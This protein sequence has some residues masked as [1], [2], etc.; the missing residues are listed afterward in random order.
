MTGILHLVKYE[1]AGNDF[2]VCLDPSGRRPFSPAEV[3]AL[4]DRHHGVG[5]DGLVRVLA[6][7]DGV[8]VRMELHNADGSAA[9]MSGNGV[10][11]VA[12]AVL[13][14][15]GPTGGLF[16]TAGAA[17]PSGD[18]L[19]AAGAA[20]RAWGAAGEDGVA[21]VVGTDA[22]PR[23]VTIAPGAGP[24]SAEGSVTMGP[25]ALGDMVDVGCLVDGPG[26]GGPGVLARRVGMGNP[27]LVVVV[28][29]LDPE[30]LHGW[31]RR[32]DAATAGGTNVELVVVHDE[33]HLELAVWERGAGATLA[34]GTG[35]CAA[36]AAAVAWGLVTVPV[37]VANPGGML[38][39]DERGGEMVLGGPSRRVAE[40]RVPEP[41][42]CHEV[43]S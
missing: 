32:V 38:W 4:C 29:R 40:V 34:C 8:D 19:V 39:V 13:D 42:L 27:H 30:H 41:L 23:R 5:A 17:G 36:A 37:V 18:L 10:R 33:R 6:G 28:P 31:A 7:G 24:G 3:R 43:G 1:G 15:G 21:V 9:E 16:V 25:A 12:H 11:C 22:G 14:A 2:L 26:P 20:G 35:S